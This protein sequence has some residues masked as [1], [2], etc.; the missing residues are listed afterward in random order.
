MTMSLL[1][2]IHI[3]YKRQPHRSSESQLC[4]SMPP[5]HWNVIYDPTN[6]QIQENICV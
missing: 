2:H 6:N 1:P 4:I 5:V 3:T